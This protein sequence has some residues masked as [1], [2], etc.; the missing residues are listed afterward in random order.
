[1]SMLE[2]IMKPSKAA[3][4]LSMLLFMIRQH[5]PPS[6]SHWNAVCAFTAT[7]THSRTHERT[8]QQQYVQRRIPPAIAPRQLFLSSTSSDPPKTIDENSSSNIDSARQPNPQ[9]QQ[10]QRTLSNQ[11]GKR[12][13]MN[14]IMSQPPTY[15]DGDPVMDINSNIVPIIDD[16]TE[17]LVNC[18]VTAADGR[19]ADNI[20]ALYVAHMTTMTSVLVVVSGNSRP[21]NQAICAAIRTAVSDMNAQQHASDSGDANDQQKSFYPQPS[22]EGTAESGWMILDYGSVMVHVM[23]PK[24]RLF[25]NVEGKWKQPQPMISSPTAAAATVMTTAIPLDLSHLL[26]PNTAAT[27]NILQQQQEQQRMYSMD[28]G[29][30]ESNS[31]IPNRSIENDFEVE[32]EKDEELD[33]FWS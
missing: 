15:T 33:P 4:L 11:Q 9:Q 26:V 6:T 14:S 18:I 29:N 24:S 20:V 19:K 10:Q 16:S 8:K 27:L 32:D 13:M 22:I 21:Q 2:T 25:Y 3:C 31:M 5:Q 7:S 12:E 28:D 1:M 30:Y 23:T 17:D